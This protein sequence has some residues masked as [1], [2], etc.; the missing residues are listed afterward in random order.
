M[1]FL[2][3]P[4]DLDREGAVRCGLPAEV[5][6]RFTMHSSDGPLESVM[7]R[8]PAGHYFSG[9]VEFLIPDSRDKHDPLITAPLPTVRAWAQ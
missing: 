4:A 3:C 8:C 1:M 9:P 5:T 6:C 7:I 2:I